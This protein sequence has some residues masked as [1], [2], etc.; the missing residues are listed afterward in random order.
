MLFGLCCLFWAELATTASVSETPQEACPPV[1]LQL[2]RARAL[3]ALK[4]GDP[5]RALLAFEQCSNAPDALRFYAM[6]QKSVAQKDW[7]TAEKQLQQ[8]L[9]ATSESPV[10]ARLYRELGEV[11]LAAQ[12]TLQAAR[13]FNRAKQLNPE[14]RRIDYLLGLTALRTDDP[15]LAQTQWN[16]LQDDEALYNRAQMQLAVYRL[17]K[18]DAQ[19]ALSLFE[20]L[21]LQALPESFDAQGWYA[22]AQQKEGQSRRGI[23]AYAGSK[24][25]YDSNVLQL[26]EDAPKE[27]QEKAAAFGLGLSLGLS[28]T[29]FVW[30]DWSL[31]GSVDLQ[32]TLYFT[33][34][35]DDFSSTQASASLGPG[36][37][38]HLFNSPARLQAHYLFA[39]TALKGGEQTTPDK[40]HVF[41]ERHQ[42][43]VLGEWEPHDRFRLRA[44][45]RGGIARYA[46]MRKDASLHE[47]RVS[48]QGAFLQ[49]RLKT[50][51]GLG[52]KHEDARGDGFT[53][54]VPLAI[55][56]ISGLLPYQFQGSLIAQCE[57][58]FHPQSLDYYGW[59]D[60]RKDRIWSLDVTLSRPLIGSWLKAILNAHLVDHG[61]TVSRFDYHRA[62]YSLG[63]TALYGG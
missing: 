7:P 29:P 32:Q 49:K 63:L 34:E 15:H 24:G 31:S 54:R 62:L 27:R 19:T 60:E 53:R 6:A 40:A 52:Y 37:R 12:K 56:G 1:T 43:E 58:G 13:S 4:N 57:L 16:A 9:K 45:Y 35:T 21:D 25:L 51:A 22:A 30:N 3:L 2:E 18:G 23:W 50:M 48:V 10:K 47:F 38:F 17:Q 26:L 36:Y 61:S 28:A 59:E 42:G 55:L 14:D 11:Q 20:T 41:M 8:A 39:L 46:D 44:Y 33:E 5:E